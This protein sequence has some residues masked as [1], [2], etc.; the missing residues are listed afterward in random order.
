MLKT[1]QEKNTDLKIYDL[2]DAA[3]RPF[4]R[5]VSLDTAEIVAAAKTIQMPADGSMYVPTEPKF[6]TLAVAK[7]IQNTFFGQMPTQMGYCWGHSNFLNAVEWHTSSEINIAVTPL[8]LFLGRVQDIENT[9]ISSDKMTAFYVPKGTALEVYATTLHFCPCEVQKTGFGCVVALPTGTN[10][11]LAVPSADPVLF[12]TN[13]WL[14]T[15]VE[16][17]VHIAKGVVP[18]VTGVNYEIRY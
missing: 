16:N 17:Q 15:H 4:G 2:S 13:K 12:R 3:F 8:I 7:E 11:D 6:E 1:L 14:L 5:V 9:T 10:T 18:G